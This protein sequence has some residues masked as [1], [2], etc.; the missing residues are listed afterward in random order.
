MKLIIYAGLIWIPRTSMLLLGFS[1]VTIIELTQSYLHPPIVSLHRMS[2]Q[3][4]GCH[5][6]LMPPIPE[7]V[8]ND[9]F[10]KKITN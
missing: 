7:L 9:Y 10:F 2:M 6:T 8:S 5:G 1:S 3:E 4:W